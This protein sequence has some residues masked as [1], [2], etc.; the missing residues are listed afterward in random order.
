[1]K[2][3]LGNHGLAGVGGTETYTA[4]VATHLQRLGHEIWIHADDQGPFA[5]GLR[6][7]GLRVPESPSGLPVAV[8]AVLANDGMSAAALAARYPGTP[9]VLV[10]HSDTF[11]MALPPKLPG[12]LS[13]VVV[14]YDRVDRRIRG[15][16]LGVPI[17]RL[18]QPIDV[19][20]FRPWRELPEQPTTVLVMGNY[21]HGERFR[22]LERA[23]AAA[24]LTCRSIG[25]HAA[26]GRIADPVAALNDADI[27]I[28]KARV[29]LEAM[30]V[31]RAAY[32]F[33]HNGGDGWVT[34]ENY[35]RHA[36][37][38]FGGQSTG[39]VL[40][41]QRI[42]DDLRAYDRTMGLTNRD[43]VVAHHAATRH[44]AELADLLAGLSER[45]ALPTAPLDE[46]ARLIRTSWSHEGRAFTLTSQLADRERRLAE[47]EAQRHD[48]Q[49]QAA[50]AHAAEQALAAQLAAVQEQ[51]AEAHRRAAEAEAR[52]EAAAERAALSEAEAHRLRDEAA[53][54]RQ[55]RRF[56]LAAALARPLDR[57][58]GA[59]ERG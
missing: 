3:V 11:D 32:V 16:D 21:V 38:N 22:L 2:I 43:L 20:R 7:D 45:P 46:I 36:A 4:T 26:A 14:L 31:G 34:A 12:L 39:D 9:L 44:A 29:I 23:C 8:D 37:D 27:V 41:E 1:M 13:G 59:G 47:A 56:R 52:A 10:G 40:D 58:R 17:T 19:E 50:Q 55:T 54:F 30:A 51:L 25:H 53:A 15:M 5:D 33:D 35:A 48:A 6:A 28:G 49:G 24:G 57:I 42:A 18:S